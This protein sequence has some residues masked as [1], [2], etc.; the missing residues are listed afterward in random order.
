MKVQELVC[1]K[2]L[3]A[4]HLCSVVTPN[5]VECAQSYLLG[6]CYNF[7]RQAKLHQGWR[8]GVESVKCSNIIKFYLQMTDRVGG[9]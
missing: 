8:F 9:I 4:S 6:F 7:E 5:G 3:F 2:F 1:P